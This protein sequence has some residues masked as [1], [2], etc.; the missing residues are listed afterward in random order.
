MTVLDASAIAFLN[1]FSG[2]SPE[3]DRIV[4]A[5]SHNELIKGGVLMTLFWWA[6]FSHGAR[7]HLPTREHLIATLTACLSPCRRR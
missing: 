6:W 7:Q 1:Q 4:H 3:F 2:A 5:I